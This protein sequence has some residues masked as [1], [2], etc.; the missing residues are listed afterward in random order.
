MTVPI[1]VPGDLVS[2]GFSAQVR[3]RSEKDRVRIVASTDGGK[4]WRAGRRH[5]RARP[6]AAPA[7]SA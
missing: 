4:T 3:A 2:L 7:T 6:R 1:E 5:E